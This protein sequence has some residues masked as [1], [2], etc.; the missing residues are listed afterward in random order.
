MATFSGK[1]GVHVLM[2]VEYGTIKSE[3]EFAPILPQGQEEET[4]LEPSQK[5]ARQDATMNVLVSYRSF[6]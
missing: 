4:A 3:G 1:A 5:L 6:Y 2:C